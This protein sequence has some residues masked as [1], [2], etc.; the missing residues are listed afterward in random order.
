MDPELQQR[1]ELLNQRFDAVDQRFDSVDRRFDAVDRRFDA[2]EQ[3]FDAVEQRFD[4]VEQRF[5]LV[6]QHVDEVKDEVK[7]HTG[8]LVEGLRHELQ[9]VAEGL[10]THI[11]TRHA[12]DRAYVDQRFQETNALIRL[13]HE[14]TEQLR[15]RVE[16]LERREPQ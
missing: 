15:Q 4:A 16:N 1:F 10:V 12:D 6:E 2:V 8:V 13:T 5:D 3:R 7:R 14:S 9:L 11:E